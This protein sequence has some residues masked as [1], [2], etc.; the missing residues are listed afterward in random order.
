MSG[1]N[2]IGHENSAAHRAD[3]SKPVRRARAAMPRRFVPLS[4][5]TGL[6]GLPGEEARTPA[7]HEAVIVAAPRCQGG[8]L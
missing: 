8:R 3:D 7:P 4:R 1:R 6:V 5:G 2:E